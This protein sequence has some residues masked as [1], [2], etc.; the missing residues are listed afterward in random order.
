[1]SEI[2]SASERLF[3]LDLELT[4]L[5]IEDDLAVEIGAAITDYRLNI[6]DTYQ[7]FIH[8]PTEIVL[9]LFRRNSWW[10]DRPEHTAAML[11]GIS[12]SQSSLLAVSR[13]VAGFA[14]KWCCKPIV[15][16]G[17]SIHNDRRW[18]DRD[19]VELRERLHYRMVDVSSLKILALGMFG[20][21][22]SKCETHRALEDIGESIEELRYLL[23]KFDAADIGGFL[24]GA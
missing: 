5:D 13:E 18:I 8:Y 16:A 22:I 21:E 2:A 11:N 3:W 23:H 14:G 7:S 24:A 17:N 12:E 6:L 19:F 20:V 4:G 9:P 1:M 15:M 10:E